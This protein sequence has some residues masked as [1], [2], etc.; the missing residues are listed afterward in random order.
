M[1]STLHLRTDS[2]I[3]MP[4]FALTGSIKPRARDSPRAASSS[5]EETSATALSVS[6]LMGAIGGGGGD[7]DDDDKEG[8]SLELVPPPPLPPLGREPN[9]DESAK[10]AGPRRVLAVSSRHRH[11]RCRPCM[12]WM[13]IR[14]L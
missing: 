3:S 11:S 6:S 7:G 1:Q 12:A 4:G 14:I 5:T 2:A 13:Q 8:G 10:I 9:A